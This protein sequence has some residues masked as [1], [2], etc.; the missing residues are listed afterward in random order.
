M[1]A[2]LFAR[3]RKG[4]L[5]AAPKSARSVLHYRKPTDRT[6]VTLYKK[7]TAILAHSV[8]YKRRFA[9]LKHAARGLAKRGLSNRAHRHPFE[10][11]FA[12][13]WAVFPKKLRLNALTA[14]GNHLP[15]RQSS[16]R[17]RRYKG[18]FSSWAGRQV[19]RNIDL[20][21]TSALVKRF[22]RQTPFETYRPKL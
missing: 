18:Y 12:T 21:Q 2:T 16:G 22:R 7:P 4:K 17:M 1:Q 10:S 3:E 8:V 19:F 15:Q 9:R 11:S 5:A 6:S 13:R 14:R 20:A